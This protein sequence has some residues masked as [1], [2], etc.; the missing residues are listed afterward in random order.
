MDRTRR[1][2]FPFTYDAFSSHRGCPV[3][4]NQLDCSL[5][6]PNA[7]CY[8]IQRTS[9]FFA[10]AAIYHPVFAEFKDNISKPQKTHT[11]EELKLTHDLFVTCAQRNR[12]LDWSKTPILSKL[13][14]GGGLVPV[15]RG[16]S[17]TKLD[18]TILVQVPAANVMMV[19]LNV[20]TKNEIGST[21][22][23]PGAKG[24]M[25]ARKSWAQ[26]EVRYISFTS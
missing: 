7:R 5:A 14:R 20:E 22:S 24:S 13:L 25:K 19:I 10:L 17:D 21:G 11:A 6:C 1:V 18:G 12:N 15:V 26:P 23:E 2:E 8:P 16:V 9:G 3:L 4:A